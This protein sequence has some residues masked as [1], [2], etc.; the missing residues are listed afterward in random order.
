ML[1]AIQPKKNLLTYEEVVKETP[2]CTWIE[3][4]N[5]LQGTITTTNIVKRRNTLYKGFV[6]VIGV[7]IT[8]VPEL[9]VYDPSIGAYRKTPSNQKYL[10]S[11]RK[12]EELR[13]KRLKEKEKE[14]QLPTADDLR[15]TL[16]DAVGT[17]EAARILGVGQRLL[18]SAVTADCQS[19]ERQLKKIGLY[20]KAGED[21]VA[22]RGSN[23]QF[24]FLVDRLKEIRKEY[25]K[26]SELFDSANEFQYSRERF[27]EFFRQYDDHFS[28]AVLLQVDD[29]PFRMDANNTLYHE[30]TVIEL[31]RQKREEFQNNY[32]ELISRGLGKPDMEKLVH[33]S[34]VSL[35]DR[36]VN[37]MQSASPQIIISD[38]VVFD[39]Q[40]TAEEAY[41]QRKVLLNIAGKITAGRCG[42]QHDDLYKKNGSVR[43]LAP[44]EAALKEWDVNL[45]DSWLNLDIEDFNYVIKDIKSY[46]FWNQKRLL[47]KFLSFVLMQ[48]EKQN[49][50]Q[51]R[52]I[53]N[54]ILGKSVTDLSSE[55][56]LHLVLKSQQLVLLDSEYED[57]FSH[58][59]AL[60]R[61]IPGEV[62][63]GKSSSS[64]FLTVLEYIQICVAIMDELGLEFLLRWE[65]CSKAGLRASEALVIA[66]EDW[67][68]DPATGL[69]LRFEGPDGT[70]GWGKIKMPDVKSKGGYGPSHESEDL[71]VPPDVTDHYEQYLKRF[72]FPL[73]PFEKHKELQD[74]TYAN[75]YVKNRIFHFQKK[76]KENGKYFVKEFAYKQGHGYIFRPKDYL[77]KG[78]EKLQDPM[79]IS[80]PLRCFSNHTALTQ[81]ISDIR[82]SFDFLP[83]DKRNNL[84]FHDGRHTLNQ[85]IETATY[86]PFPESALEEVADIVMR[87][88]IQRKNLDTGKKNYRKTNQGFIVQS[89]DVFR[90]LYGTIG[91]KSLDRD[92]S[93][94]K[95]W[96]AETGYP[97]TLL[98][99]EEAKRA[100]EKKALEEQNQKLQEN[101]EM[102]A[103]EKQDWI[104]EL[105]IL[106]AKLKQSKNPPKGLSK[107]EFDDWRNARMKVIKRVEQLKQLLDLPA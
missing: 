98:Q 43:I 35:I 22:F 4:K 68:H 81:F 75:G 99:A 102:L 66:V 19:E 56:L 95:A 18:K 29:G 93:A 80:H 63:S 31:F 27:F 106:E 61:Q 50:S 47:I 76:V 28:K 36:F 58:L 41:E 73:C 16:G 14:K 23:N 94:F 32:G 46:S 84:T 79:D 26:P 49:K 85:W 74:G 30:K 67:I 100:K 12:L 48:E 103:Q 53:R 10:F 8:D 89:D 52:K 86:L 7:N 105:A 40:W 1:T 97:T 72:L 15:D 44:N 2:L 21:Y 83:K 45:F 55:Q 60:M 96:A 91:F 25:K 24:L 3:A 101:R 78:G 62:W 59:K 90:I 13:D 87:H 37:H 20:Y 5:I 57:S 107:E 54:D 70:S 17:Y 65:L 69:P 33:P 11:V 92:F 82:M 6:Y 38:D 9:T 51:K 39:D 42:I 71:P 64:V 77:R 88:D 104:D 34:V